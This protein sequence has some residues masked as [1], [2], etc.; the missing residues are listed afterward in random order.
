M[1]QYSDDALAALRSEA[2]RKGA[3]LLPLMYCVPDGCE[4]DDAVVVVARSTTRHEA[5]QYLSKPMTSLQDDLNHAMTVTLAVDGDAS[6]AGVVG[7]LQRLVDLGDGFVGRIIDE[8]L[9]PLGFLRQG[10]AVSAVI[11]AKTTLADIEKFGLPTSV[12]DLRSKYTSPGAL[13]MVR[14]GDLCS[15]VL[16]RPSGDAAEQH[17]KMM[18]RGNKAFQAVLDYAF[19]HIVSPDKAEEKRALFERWPAL[20]WN[21]LDVL[22]EM[23]RGGARAEGKGLPR[24]SAPRAPSGITRG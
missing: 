4:E 18:G 20:G 16:V 19:D 1:H 3:E 24:G 17:A 11:N 7:G 6:G 10:D 12:I 23:R 15:V 5:A 21:L 14:V 22:Y 2:E 8:S 9:R 13:R